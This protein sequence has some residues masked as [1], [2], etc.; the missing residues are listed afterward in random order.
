MLHKKFD[1]GFDGDD[2]EMSLNAYPTTKNDDEELPFSK[3]RSMRRTVVA[4]P[5]NELPFSKPRSMRRTVAEPANQPPAPAEEVGA[6]AD[7]VAS[8]ASAAE[9]SWITNPAEAAVEI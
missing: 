5:A 2:D 4:E 9:P 8:S 3:P 1:E 6:A 7:E